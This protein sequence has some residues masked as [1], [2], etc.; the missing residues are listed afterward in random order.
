[1]VSCCLF[2]CNGERC[3]AEITNKPKL[4]IYISFK[5][6]YEPE[7]YLESI[8]CKAHQSLLAWLREGT[9]PLEIETGRYVGL[10][11]EQRIW[12][13]CKS[14]VE[15]KVYFVLSSLLWPCHTSHFFR[16]WRPQHQVSVTCMTSYYYW[17]QK[18]AQEKARYGMIHKVMHETWLVSASL[19]YN[20][21]KVTIIKARSITV[22][23]PNFSNQISNS[24]V[25][26]TIH[27]SVPMTKKGD[28]NPHYSTIVV[29]LITVVFH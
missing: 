12:K 2:R 17:I 14:T 3:K 24:N 13:L 4:R 6:T 5:E 10:P 16:Q 21:I 25:W 8:R 26:S 29:T 11:P 20:K 9:A 15:D 22:I 19:I 28:Y 18:R 1:M 23:A 7:E 27:F